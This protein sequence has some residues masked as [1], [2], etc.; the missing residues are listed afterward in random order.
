MNNSK[1]KASL[2]NGM[3]WTSGGQFLT[4]LVNLFVNILLARYLSPDEFGVMGIVMFFIL[5]SDV[6]SKGGL[7]GALIRAKE[8]DSKD[9]STIFLFNLAV[10]LV[11]YVL[12]FS[13]STKIANFY[14]Q[15]ILEDLLIFTGPI[16][17]VTSFQFINMTKLLRE[18]KFKRRF[19][20]QF[21]ATV[22]GGIIAILMASFGFGVWSLVEFQ[23]GT[24]IIL[25][26]FLFIF[27]GRHKAPFVFDI[28]S[29]RKNYAYGVN[30]SLASIIDTVFENIYSLVLGK[31]FSVSQVGYFYQAQKLQR[32]PNNVLNAF[33]QRVMFPILAKKQDSVDSFNLI[34]SK[35]LVT[36]TVFVG[37]LGLCIFVYS[38]S[39]VL[40]LFGEEWLG[41]VFFLRLLVVSTFFYMQEQF[42]KVIFKV[43]NQTRT[44][45]YLEIIKKVFQIF[46]ILIGIYYYDIK[47]LIYGIIATSLFSFFINYFRSR[48]IVES[49]S[50][51]E[52][53]MIIKVFLC[54]AFVAVS[55]ELFVLPRFNNYYL[56]FFSFPFLFIS[57]FF[58][59]R[60]SF[61]FNL[62]EFRN[63]V[64]GLNIK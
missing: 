17:V 3:I 19:L 16:L 13:F 25:A 9:Y 55:F 61:V 49:F 33:S 5:F 23:L 42:N 28:P 53:F 35:L 54:A 63:I 38:K 60:I 21:S 2:L 59:L 12:I 45:L 46:T 41:S 14:N 15:P 26:S 64:K 7:G 48:I 47:V 20:Y 10:S 1:L 18:L 44:M 37:L 27:E 34:Y 4:V 39:I 24:A 11:L 36:F 51:F 43:F 30:T 6:L 8:V 22:I 57:Y 50:W 56:V 29:F 31:Y 58:L 62:F 40:I 32:V 52:I